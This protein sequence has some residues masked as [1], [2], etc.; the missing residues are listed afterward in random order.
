VTHLASARHDGPATPRPA[1]TRGPHR[2]APHPRWCDG[3]HERGGRDQRRAVPGEAWHTVD[4]R[5][6][7]GF[8]EG[9]RRQ[10][11]GRWQRARTLSDLKW[12]SHID[13]AK[14]LSTVFLPM[15]RQKPVHSPPRIVCWIEQTVLNLG[16]DETLPV[17]AVPIDS[18]VNQPDGWQPRLALIAV[19]YSIF[20]LSKL[21]F[22][23]IFQ[24]RYDH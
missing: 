15:C 2:S 21:H 17:E 4:T 14:P 8:G 24:R 16:F 23:V 18:Q 10:Y 11:G 3:A 7:N 9:H 6:L 12:S 1:S 22:Y 13:S 19:R 5:G 20:H